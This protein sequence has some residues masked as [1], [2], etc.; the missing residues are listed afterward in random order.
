MSKDEAIT[1][2]NGNSGNGDGVIKLTTVDGWSFTELLRHVVS[3]YTVDKL[4]GTKGVKSEVAN[5]IGAT[6]AAIAFADSNKES[7]CDS[8]LVEDYKLPSGSGLLEL[9]NVASVWLF[10]DAIDVPG[11]Q[12]FTKDIHIAALNSWGPIKE[13]NGRPVFDKSYCFTPDRLMTELNSIYK[14]NNQSVP[15]YMNVKK[16]H[17]LWNEVSIVGSLKISDADTMLSKVISMFF[18]FTNEHLC[19]YGVPTIPE[20]ER[21]IASWLFSTSN[22]DVKEG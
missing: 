16:S 7:I 10:S 13:E 18:G 19:E 12:I 11:K 14:L 22:G 9:A 20:S 4:F 17:L 21:A 15:A 6:I 5:G 8:Y 1:V 2:S 3:N